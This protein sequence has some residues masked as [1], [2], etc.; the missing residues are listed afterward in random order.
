MNSFEIRQKFLD[1]Y[2]KNG[3]EIV[4]SSSLI[5]ANDPTLLFAN[6]GM[7]Q[8]KDIFLGKETRSYKRACT[9]QKCVRAGGK[10]NDL[11]E[12]GFTNRH[13]TFFEMMGNFSFG[14]YFKKE[15]IHFAWDFLT[16]EI[17][18]SPERLVITIYKD[19]DQ[20]YEIWNKEIKIPHEKITRLGEKDNFWQMGDTG[21]CGPCTEIHVDHGKHLGCKKAECS[22]ACS[23]GRFTEIW[24]LVFMQFDRQADGKL[25]PLKKTGV[26]T[27]MGL[28]RICMTLQEKSSVFETDLFHPLIK[29]LEELTQINYKK[30]PQNI[31]S[32]FNVL[33]DHARSSSLLIADGCVPSNEGRGYVLRKIIRRAAL[34]SQ[35]LSDNPKLFSSVAN[36]FTFFM[37]TIYPE[38]KTNHDQIISLIENEIERFTTNLIQGQNILEKFIQDALEQKEKVL[39]GK[40][41]FKLYDTYGFP[42]ELTRVMATEKNLSLD[43]VGFEKEM[44]KQQELSGKKE[45]AEKSALQ[46]PANITTKFAGYEKLETKSKISFV[47]QEN[48]YIWIVTE[49][50]PFY[51]ESG[52]QVSD[53][54]FVVI[55]E[56]TFPIIEFSKEAGNLNPAI[57]IKISIQNVPNIKI[58]VGDIAHCVVDYIKRTNSAKNHTATHLLQ[59][60][61]V[62]ILGKQI[63]QS[64]SFVND[65]YLRFD[66]THHQA[67]TKEETEKVENLVNQ[68]IQENIKLNIFL[69]T[70]KSATEQGVTAFFGEKYNPE[71]VRVVQ[72]HDFSSELCGGT[73]VD[74]TGVIG[75]F[76]IESQ[77]A[78]SAGTRRITALTG[79]AAIK[80]FQ[81]DYNICKI[82]AEKFK[83]KPDQVLQTIEK[84]Q[85]EIGE[86]QHTIKHLKKM[87]LKAQVP[88]W[89]KK[90]K[91]VGKIPFLFIELEDLDG[92]QF[93]QLCEEIESKAPGFYFVVSKN[94]KN[95]ETINFFGFL[96]HPW[97][98][99]INLKNFITF[100]K[101]KFEFKGGGSS[102][103]I[104]GS[105]GQPKDKDLNL[106]KEITK[107][108]KLI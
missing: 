47:K 1:F 24:N 95:P 80:L 48:S 59:A 91:L 96:S 58:K 10:H 77:T 107:W 43:M 31:K 105:G 34:F 40:H 33:L 51:V 73:H 36:E 101:E 84:Q 44:Q 46:L 92:S 32:A 53:Q 3:H 82:L 25:N 52:G 23:C 8:F 72:I 11:D 81:Q 16:K 93:K 9:I 7:N 22:P 88:S 41:I 35:K 100:L 5:P 74:S 30:S 39:A 61:L 76:K 14:D 94:T 79:P 42:P 21:P 99:E 89:Q 108:I 87:F 64:G 57:A 66:F 18:L 49:E 19:D 60:S 56:H 4:A 28:E 65:Q 71:N 106:E 6:A 29:K 75:C 68:K 27:G 70:L 103:L 26:D 97:E 102:N 55:Q 13:L 98:N 83:V 2:R 67:L 38:L 45:S 78:L 15:A 54:G 17:G 86:L 69:T 62:Q 90:V 20:A 12:V 50:S 37:S 85:E 104:Q 63:K